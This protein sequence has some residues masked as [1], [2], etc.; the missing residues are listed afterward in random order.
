MS[1]HMTGRKCSI[2]HFLVSDICEIPLNHCCL[3]VSVFHFTSGT[4][5]DSKEASGD[6][7]VV[8][9]NRSAGAGT[10]EK[11]GLSVGSKPFFYDIGWHCSHLPKTKHRRVPNNWS[12]MPENVS[13]SRSKRTAVWF[14]Q[15]EN[16]LQANYK[17]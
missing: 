2:Y 4:N 3:F 8:S 9:G 10:G 16:V 6:G 14:V 11:S 12:E 15:N 17:E 7:L 5:Q 1:V 13:Q